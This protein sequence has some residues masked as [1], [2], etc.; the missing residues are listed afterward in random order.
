[1][2]TRTAGEIQ[3]ERRWREIVAGQR[4][5]GQS[6]RAYCRQVGVA[7]PAF[8]WWRRKLAQRSRQHNHLPQ[9]RR[10]GRQGRL[11]RPETRKPSGASGGVEFLPL[12]IEAGHRAPSKMVAGRGVKAG[13]AIEVVLGGQRVLRIAPGFD[14][15]TLAEVLAVL[16]ARPC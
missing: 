5:S 14:R 16:E 13:P 1:M 9:P 15:Q 3:R 10:G 11:A 7:E 6:V 8:Y 12:R 4:R 2:K